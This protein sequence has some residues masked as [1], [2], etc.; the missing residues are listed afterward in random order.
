MRAS[1]DRLDRAWSRL[2]VALCAA[3][4]FALVA[5]LSLWV[6][7]KGL[8]AKTTDAFV[9]G[10]LLRSLIAGA[11]FGALA[12][13]A[14]AAWKGRWPRTA[15]A[16]AGA[17]AGAG[18]GSVLRGAGVDYFSN[19][20]GWLQDG[21][22]LTLVGG[23]RGL[24]TR[25]T[26]FVALLGASLATAAGR[27][28]SIDVATRAF[29]PRLRARL[30]LAG[31]A[32]AG[33]VCLFSAWGFFDFIAV[34]AF[35]ARPGSAP[36]EALSAVARGASRHAFLA[37]RQLAMDARMLGRVLRGEPWSASLAPAEWNVWL[38]AGDWAGHF[39]PEVTASLREADG[40]AA[41]RS[42][43]VSVPAEP[44]RGLLVKTLDLI[45]P[46]GL[47]MM[48]LRFLLWALR[49]GPV[50]ELHGAPASSASPSERT[51]EPALEP[52]PR[53]RLLALGAVGL[54]SAG[55]SAGG[56]WAASL[57]TLSALAGA[58][59]FAVMAGGAALAFRLIG[60]PLNR[61]APKVL[62]EQFAGS[63]VLVTIPLFTALGYVLAESKAPGR[64]VEAS[65]AL[66]G[67]LPGGL[68]LVCLG[69]SAFFTTLTGGSGVTIVAIGG[70]LLPTLREQGYSERF[71]L[72]LVT[73]GG[74]L[75]LL[76]PPSLPILVYA[77]VA[78]LDFAPAFKAGL[79]PGLLVLAVLGGYAAYVGV[80]ERVPR[81]PF[82]AGKALRAL[83]HVKWELGI[84]V[85]IL[86]GLGAGLTSL[87][88][89]AAVALAYAL[90]VALAVHR[91]LTLRDLPRILRQSMALAGAVILI[92]MMAN[93]L[94]NFVI[95]QQVPARV[96]RSLL[97]LGL[98]ERWQFLVVLNLFLLVV[99]MVMDGFSAILVAVPLVLPFAARFGLHPF[100]LA[101]MF[102]LN[103]ELAFCAPPLGLNLFIASFRFRR[104]VASLYRSALPFVGLLA[105]CLAALMA[106][107]GLSTRLVQPDIDAA[108]AQAAKLGVA[109]REAWNL[110]CVQEDPTNP[111]PC[112]DAERAKWA[113]AASA[114]ESDDLDDALMKQMMDEGEKKP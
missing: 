85:L 108:R 48:A 30:S 72:G 20:L 7:L 37:R 17:A 34:D 55:A 18:L 92:L 29:G 86:G 98:A 11:L 44:S 6:V 45:I 101:M 75:G 57:V 2:E 69:S 82:E 95:D 41:P 36:L 28:V 1:L 51:E 8:S 111:R 24:G 58:P 84:P 61:L 90:A 35:G 13:L 9:G 99:G 73:T 16:F 106:V 77:L 63:P 4:A 23:L 31:G 87:D 26:L 97:G 38:D 40:A 47:L 100:H 114:K 62:D 56:G 43:L 103:L 112:S 66:F 102:I 67:W 21:S 109:P 91:D 33:V 79:L 50:E 15:L 19:L 81:D 89:S 70:L 80:R 49:K 83:W 74:S 105:L 54:V 14:G 113:P 25:L 27:H 68:A 10:L 107:P 78:G 64:I 3:A 53:A 65:R 59:L 96:L 22:S 39:G 52:A 32:L 71:S 104:P 12:W 93:A 46:F 42:P 5:S 88:E 60:S 76:L 110:E 94:M